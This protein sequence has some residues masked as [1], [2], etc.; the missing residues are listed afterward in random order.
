MLFCELLLSKVGLLD[1]NVF[2][3]FLINFAIF[4]QCCLKL[5]SLVVLLFA[6]TFGQLFLC[7]CFHV[8]LRLAFLLYEQANVFFI[9]KVLCFIDVSYQLQSAFCDILLADAMLL[10]VGLY[11]QL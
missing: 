11:R 9:P 8:Y 7:V 4:S 1:A 10:R 5:L 6:L 3:L 2:V